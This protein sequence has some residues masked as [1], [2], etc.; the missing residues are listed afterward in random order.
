MKR[1][2]GTYRGMEELQA[3]LASRQLAIRARLADFA[4]VKPED[5]FFELVYCLLT[6]QSSAVNAGKAVALLQARGI[7][8]DCTEL[9][10][11]LHQEEFY[12]RFHNTKAR[13]ILDAHG[14]FREIEVRIAGE[15]DAARLREWLVLNVKGLGWKEASHFLRNIGCRNLAILDRHILRN[16]QRHRVIRSLPK[17]LTKKQYHTIEQK[18]ARFA[19]TVGISMDELDLLFWSRETGEILK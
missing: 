1:G 18:F 4:A 13:H 11:L 8:A 19:E 17:T 5:Y 9:A 16:L 12:I 7:C 10:A 2:A 6:P 15:K 3:E 14:K